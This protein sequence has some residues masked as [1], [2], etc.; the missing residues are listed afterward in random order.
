MMNNHCHFHGLKETKIGNLMGDS[1]L[2]AHGQYKEYYL[3]L[4]L[5]KSLG[6]LLACLSQDNRVASFSTMGTIFDLPK[7]RLKEFNEAFD[8]MY[9]KR[10]NWVIFNENFRKK[11]HQLVVQTFVPTY[12]SYLQ[13]YSLL[14]EHNDNAARNVKY[15]VQSL[16][17]MFS[18][19][20]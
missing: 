9:K 5:R 17:N 7:K 19:L 6:K 1:W 20:F 12:R 4:Y 15:T 16:E 3:A 13:K 18:T 10:L 8:D 2:S 11:I 14:V